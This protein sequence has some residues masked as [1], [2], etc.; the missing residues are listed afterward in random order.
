MKREHG[1]A[2]F[3]VF[4]GLLAS[5]AAPSAWSAD[6]P[7]LVQSVTVANGKVTPD[8]KGP[9]QDLITKLQ[10]AGTIP[11]NQDFLKAGNPR[12][13]T[14]VLA[15]RFAKSQFNAKNFGSDG[16]AQGVYF[17]N[18]TTTSVDDI[19]VTMNNTTDTFAGSTGN[20]DWKV[21][22]TPPDAAKGIAA[23][24]TITATAAGGLAKDASLWLSIPAA[25]KNIDATTP[26]QFT[27]KLTTKNPVAQAPAPAPP[28]ALSIGTGQGAGQP[29]TSY[30]AGTSTL[31][32]T[33]GT[34]K[35]ARYVDGSTTTTNGPTESII[36][37]KVVIQPTTFLGADP[38]VP[39]AFDFADTL[40][41]VFQGSTLFEDATLGD[42][43][44]FK[45]GSGSELY[46]TLDWQSLIPGLGSQYIYQD[47]TASV[48]DA[49]YLDGDLISATSGFTHSGSSEGPL[50]IAS[51]SGVP[52][53]S[54]WLLLFSGFACLAL[55]TGRGRLWGATFTPRA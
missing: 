34:V 47:L 30:N 12:V 29:T 20:A 54:T 3:V 22:V 1:R 37:A 42:L 6:Y 36:G 25:E 45:T 43:T 14:N 23:T 10:N 2:C 27:G 35:F 41:Q 16:F 40:V 11:K 33:D 46:G 52:E 26:W 49:L 50:T 53:S 5:F 15:N 48:E 44:V 8:G 18:L 32:F 7:F 17:Q 39:G 24:L 28:L 19:E 9:F 4:A 13:G 21:T 55:A 38:H 51:I 31:S